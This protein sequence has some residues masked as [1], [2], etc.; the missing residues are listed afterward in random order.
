[1]IASL[2]S[3]DTLIY[4]LNMTPKS[5]FGIPIFQDIITHHLAVE[6]LEVI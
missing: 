3:A 6:Y 2:C 4:F 5:F 1:M